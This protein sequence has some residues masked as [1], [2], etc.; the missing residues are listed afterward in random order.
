MTVAEFIGDEVSAAGYRLCGVDVH[1]ADESNALSLIR[2]SCER[3]SL[4]LVGSSLAQ[5]LQ[6]ADLDALLASIE[7]PVL[8]VPDVSD[9][10]DVPDIASRV[11][12]QLGLLE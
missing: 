2:K 5:Q 3:A 1:I 4:V 10:H 9:S 12:K 8:V 7:P 11:N 6:G